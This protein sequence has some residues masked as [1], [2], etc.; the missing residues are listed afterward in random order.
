MGFMQY[1]FKTPIRNVWTDIGQFR[2]LCAQIA[3]V[4]RVS[5]AA[6]D[7]MIVDRGE[8]R[9]GMPY[10]NPFAGGS[11]SRTMSASSPIPVT[12]SSNNDNSIN[13]KIGDIVIQGDADDDTVLKL[14]KEKEDIIQEMFKRINKHTIFSGRKMVRASN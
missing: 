4:R 10:A 5:R 7:K 9:Y 1:I 14:R 6:Y 8:C 13:I 12:N 3:S 11:S 2:A